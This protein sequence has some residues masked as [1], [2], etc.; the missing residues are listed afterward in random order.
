MNLENNETK[1]LIFAGLFHDI[2]KFYQRTGRDHNASFKKYDSDDF[3]FGGAHAKWSADFV[4]NIAGYNDLVCDLVLH[5]HKYNKAE[6]KDL[7]SIIARADSHSAFERYK[8]DVKQDPDNEPLV[9]IFSGISLDDNVNNDCYVN[10]EKLSLRDMSG[11]MPVDSKREARRGYSNLVSS[12]KRLWTNFVNEFKRVNDIYDFDTV[13][14]LLK[15]YT[16]TIPSAVYTSVPDISLY[17]HSKTTS[18]IGLVRYMYDMKTGE[19]RKTSD[20]Q[21]VYLLVNGDIS[22]I[23]HF[24]YRISSPQDAQKGMSRRLRGRSLYISLLCDAIVRYIIDNLDLCSANVLFSAGGRFTILADNTEDT[25]NKIKDIS[26]LINRY[27]IDNFNSELYLSLVC[28]GASGD[29]FRDYGSLNDKLGMLL[30]VDK[31]HK[32]ADS[33]VSVFSLEDGVAYNICSICGNVCDDTV[34]GMCHSHEELGRSALNARY[35]LV[36]NSYEDCGDFDMYIDSLGIGYIFVDSDESLLGNIDK[37]SNL[38]SHVEICRLNDTDFLSLTDS[39]EMSNVSFTFK[40]MGN[41]VPDTSCDGIL[42]FEQLASL[43]KG[44]SK[45]GVLK[46]DVDN[47]GLIFSRGFDNDIKESGMSISRVSTLSSYLDMF[48]AGFINNIAREFTVYAASDSTDKDDII[49]VLSKDEEKTLNFTR[50]PNSNAPIPTIYINYSGGDDLLVIGPYD[51]VIEFACRLR[52]EF[53]KWTCDNDSINISGGIAIVN[54]KFPIGKAVEIADNNLSNSKKAGKNKITLFNEIFEWDDNEPFI[55]FNSLLDYG[56]ELEKYVDNGIISKGF[57]YSLLNMW[58]N[59]YPYK[60]SNINENEWKH[61]N[62][63]RLRHKSYVP[64]YKYRLRNIKDEDVRRYIDKNGMK[65]MPWIK[66]PVS[67][68][69]LRTR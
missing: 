13:L 10:L 63:E 36:C 69:S 4:F 49:P 26:R 40:F 44:S 23:Q 68:V 25:R 9:S 7:C 11:L 32:F 57:I 2:G 16:S 30:S 64:Y 41:T 8:S 50:T 61:D 65:Y 42:S 24:I 37:Y 12:Y 3:G 28:T 27:F 34:C 35:L 47:L 17:D 43:S 15:K 52:S 48:F 39:V 29:D 5:H 20:K 31:Q 45:M 46:M 22:G 54:G 19:L 21:D 67:W 33:L 53:K 6:N 60:L 51:D 55:G 59:N 38:F 18:A 56:K 14:F 66:I 1:N 58:N 62:R